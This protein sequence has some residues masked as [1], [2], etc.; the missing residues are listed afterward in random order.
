[1]GEALMMGESHPSEDLRTLMRCP[2]GCSSPRPALGPPILESRTPTI[3]S[4]FIKEF[5]ESIRLAGMEV[6]M[7]HEKG[8]SERGSDTSL[9]HRTC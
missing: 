3:E 6:E 2:E 9:P 8:V 7:R 4:T 5:R 1:M